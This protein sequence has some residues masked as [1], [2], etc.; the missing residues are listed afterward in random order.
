MK[1][2]RDNICSNAV[3]ISRVIYL[4]VCFCCCR[5][6]EK[7]IA[8]WKLF[9]MMDQDMCFNF[10]FAQKRDS[11]AVTLALFFQPPFSLHQKLI[12]NYIPCECVCVCKS[13]LVVVQSCVRISNYRKQ[14]S[15]FL[16]RRSIERNYLL[17][18]ITRISHKT[19]M[20][21]L[22]EYIF[23]NQLETSTGAHDFRSTDLLFSRL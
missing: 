4:Y 22:F 2:W 12:F 9:L 15:F 18:F 7:K 11:Q 19:L 20:K 13:A 6:N 8:R 23:F 21:R 17:A 3:F 10:F 16:P 5:W 1:P 14:R